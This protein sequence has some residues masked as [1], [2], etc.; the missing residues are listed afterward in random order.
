MRPHLGRLRGRERVEAPAHHPEGGRRHVLEAAALA[1]A[2]CYEKTKRL[3]RKFRHLDGEPLDGLARSAAAAGAPGAIPRQR[4]SHLRRKARARRRRRPRVEREEVV[5]VGPR[6]RR[7][8]HRHEAVLPRRAH[9]PA[10]RRGRAARRPARPPSSRAA[11]GR[12]SCSSSSRWASSASMWRGRATTE[13]EAKAGT[14]GSASARRASGAVDVG[15]VGAQ[16]H[17]ARRQ[18]DDE[19]DLGS[20]T[21]RSGRAWRFTAAIARALRDATGAGRP[22]A[23]RGRPR[24]PRS[25]GRRG[26]PGG[27]RRTGRRPALPPRRAGG[28]GPGRTGRPASAGCPAG[29]PSSGGA[30]AGRADAGATAGAGDGAGSGTAAG[31]RRRGD[32]ELGSGR[33]RRLGGA[34]TPASA[35]RAPPTRARPPATRASPPGSRPSP[36]HASSVARSTGPYS[37]PSGRC[38]EVLVGSWLSTPTRGRS[39]AA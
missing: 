35:R 7:A 21:R 16:G 20:S 32:D 18:V 12:R 26:P 5:A 31:S 30:T 10:A 22:T 15:V 28:S 19:A 9:E 24:R 25:P 1:H 37:V 33:G 8:L 34:G 38:S 6:D 14:A 27:R 17:P 3:A 23:R 29:R 11:R 36:C 39:G 13:T 2:L 4:A